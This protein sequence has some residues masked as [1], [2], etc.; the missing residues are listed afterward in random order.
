MAEHD[1]KSETKRKEEGEG[2]NQDIWTII[3]KNQTADIIESGASN[4]PN[5]LV[6]GAKASGK[7]TVIETII[8]RTGGSSKTH[9]GAPDPTT[10]LDYRYMGQGLRSGAHVLLTHIWE[11][12]GGQSLTKLVDISINTDSLERSGVVIVLDLSNPKSILA[13]ITYWIAV[14]S[15]RISDVIDKIS[16]RRPK[17][18]ETLRAKAQNRVGGSKHLDIQSLQK[19]L[20][21]LPILIVA[22]KFDKFRD[23]SVEQLRSVAGLLRSFALIYGGALI[24]VSKS[25]SS[26][27]QA[28]L[29]H[30][31]EIQ[32]LQRGVQEKKSNKKPPLNTRDVDTLSVPFG[33]DSLQALGG[34]NSAGALQPEV[35]LSEWSKHFKKVFQ[36]K[37]TK[38]GGESENSNSNLNLNLN[39][40]A[41]VDSMLQQ[42]NIKAKRRIQREALA[43]KMANAK[44]AESRPGR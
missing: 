1:Y 30:I 31:C 36:L 13:D 40:E 44:A 20:C 24:Y 9:S 29:A 25:D 26:S 8:N 39:S 28:L 11:L 18:A 22:N 3:Q 17:A 15:K 43:R 4:Q 38:D 33:A 7:T 12:G 27:R 32:R 41:A 42:C 2:G 19:S 37:N 5:L 34:P 23:N 21:P 14:I 16:A 10:S 6:V 35:V